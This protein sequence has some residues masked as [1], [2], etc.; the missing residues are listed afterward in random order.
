MNASL[1]TSLA[2]VLVAAIAAAA[3]IASQRAAANA[4]VRNTD[5]TSRATIEAQAFDR[6]KSYYTDTIDRQAGEISELEGDVAT[7]KSKVEDQELELRAM[8]IE[9]DTAQRA[10]RLKFP[11]EP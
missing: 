3:A 7:L 9:L 6:A 8:R 11:D 10:L 4:A 1:L 2:S 5:T